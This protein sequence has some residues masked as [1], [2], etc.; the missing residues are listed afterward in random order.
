MTG[1]EWGDDE[2]EPMDIEVNRCSICGL[3]RPVRKMGSQWLCKGC[4]EDR[5]FAAE[6]KEKP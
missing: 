1:Y 3:I 5:L 6:R 4:D 2:D